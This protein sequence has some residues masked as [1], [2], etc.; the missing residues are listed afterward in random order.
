MYLLHNNLLVFQSVVFQSFHGH[1]H[2]HT[3]IHLLFDHIVSPQTNRLCDI[4]ERIVQVM[5]FCLVL[6]LTP[7]QSD[8]CLISLKILFII[9]QLLFSIQL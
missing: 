4:L 6:M 8:T 9:H 2:Q 5:E 7:S 1:Y 3:N